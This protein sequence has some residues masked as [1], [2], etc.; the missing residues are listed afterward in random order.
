MW[1]SRVPHASLHSGVW[2]VTCQAALLAM[3]KGRALLCEWA[4]HPPHVRVLPLHV[5]LSIASRAAV[6]TFWD[7]LA[8]FVGLQLYPESWVQHISAT[9]P[10]I[11]AVLSSPEGEHTLA[12]NR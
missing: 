7:M 3:D 5:Q 11:A 1:L 9:H 2:M 8:D 6:A 4:L 12:V 10:F